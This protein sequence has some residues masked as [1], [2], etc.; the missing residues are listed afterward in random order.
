MWGAESQSRHHKTKSRRW[1][2]ELR[3]K[4]IIGTLNY[5][6]FSISNSTVKSTLHSIFLNIMNTCGRDSYLPIKNIQFFAIILHCYWKKS[7]T[8]KGTFCNPFTTRLE[9]TWLMSSG[10]EFWWKKLHIFLFMCQLDIKV[11]PLGHT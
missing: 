9:V 5:S 11:L 10:Q 1:C 3:D 7:L 4:L 8:A 6:K 2:F